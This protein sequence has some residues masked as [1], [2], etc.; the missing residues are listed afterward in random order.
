M[1]GKCVA[2]KFITGRTGKPSPAAAQ[3][4]SEDGVGV[5]TGEERGLKEE[6]CRERA[7]LNPGRAGRGREI[8]L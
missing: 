7:L 5:F 4:I 1:A 8:L 6:Q 3:A 2:Q